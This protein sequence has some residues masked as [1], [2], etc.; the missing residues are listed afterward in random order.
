MTFVVFPA[1][2][3]AATPAIFNKVAQLERKKVG[4][5]FQ[6][7][8]VL[9]DCPRNCGLFLSRIRKERN[10]NKASRRDLARNAF[11]RLNCCLEIQKRGSS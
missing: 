8:H 2:A 10:F 11:D 6:F 7:L 5:Y 9:S 1:H 3:H 4:Q